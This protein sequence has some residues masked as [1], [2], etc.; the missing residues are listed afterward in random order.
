VPIARLNNNTALAGFK[1][2]EIEMLLD[3]L[4]RIRKNVAERGSQL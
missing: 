1:K 2:A 4:R 3:A